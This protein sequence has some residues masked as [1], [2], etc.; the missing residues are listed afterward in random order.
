MGALSVEVARLR[1]SSP[2]L[3]CTV[4]SYEIQRDVIS[5]AV[6]H[7]LDLCHCDGGVALFGDAS[8]GLSDGGG[9][10]SNRAVF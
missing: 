1:G 2:I 7:W 3:R 9:A 4:K 5:V 10:D 8:G 6:G